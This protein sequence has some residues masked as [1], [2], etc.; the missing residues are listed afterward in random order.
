MDALGGFLAER[1]G[2]FCR[3]GASRHGEQFELVI[4]FNAFHCKRE[5]FVIQSAAKE[6]SPH[7]TLRGALDDRRGN[8]ISLAGWSRD[9]PGTHAF[10]TRT[11]PL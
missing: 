1:A 2:R 8:V 4:H 9:T 3:G 6:F 10:H 11:P 7:A 5:G